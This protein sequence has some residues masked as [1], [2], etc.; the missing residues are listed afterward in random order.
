[1]R[2]LQSAYQNLSQN[3]NILL[4][5]AATSAFHE[6]NACTTVCMKVRNSLAIAQALLSILRC[7]A[8][9]IECCRHLCGDSLGEKGGAD[10][11]HIMPVDLPALLGKVHAQEV[12]PEGLQPCAT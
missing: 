1:M 5:R 12:S 10:L 7:F 6:H 9:R 8:G 3:W 11:G 4:F 2:R